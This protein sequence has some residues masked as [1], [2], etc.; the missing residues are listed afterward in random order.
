MGPGPGGGGPNH[1]GGAPAPGGGAGGGPSG[2]AGGGPSGWA[3]GGPSGWAGG[4]PPGGSGWVPSG[5]L[6]EPVDAATGLFVYEHTDFSIPDVIPIQ[7][8]RTYR[9]LDTGSRAFGIG[10]SD[11]YDITLYLDSGGSYTYADLILADASDIHY[12]RTSSGTSYLDAVFQNSSPTPFYGSTITWTGSSW[13]LSMKDGSQMV[14]GA[15]SLLDSMTDR[16]GNTLSI[17][18]DSNNNL[19]SVVSPNERGLYFT[20]DSS[21]R[22]TQAEDDIGRTTGYSYNAAGY[23]ASVTDQNGGVTSYSY[24]SAGRMLSFTTPNGNVHVTNQYDSNNRVTEQTLP[25]GGIYNFAY[26]LGSGGNVAATTMIDPRGSSCSMAFNSSGYITSDIWAMTKPEQVE[27]TYN[28]DPNTNLVSSVTDAL[29]RTT[30]Y[31]YDS[32]GNLASVTSLAGTSS[33]AT[34]SITYDPTFSQPTSLTDPLGHTW[35]LTLDSKGNMTGSTD[36]LGH[37]TTATYNSAGQ[38]ATR[39]DALG[40]TISFCL[41]RRHS[42]FRYRSAGQHQH[43]LSGRRRADRGIHGPA[44]QFN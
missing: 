4:G 28:R 22:I 21:G 7:L 44:G 24:D 8:Q 38:V 39:A 14:F 17:E 23:L 29:G 20:T 16:N 33:A 10:T 13:L 40:N 9:E 37:E 18:R 26:E 5:R 15:G 34:T 11:N 27:D 25:D 41:Y 6:G 3:G 42:H 35:T 2:W 36:P 12:V 43:L 30:A 1:C 32:L 31:T 19:Q